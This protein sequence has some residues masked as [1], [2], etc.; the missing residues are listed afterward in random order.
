MQDF[1]ALGLMFSF[2]GFSLAYLELCKRLRGGED[3]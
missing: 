2:V 1:L 3:V